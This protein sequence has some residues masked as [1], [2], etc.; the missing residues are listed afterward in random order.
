MQRT[1]V[2]TGSAS[3]IGQAAAAAFAA[4]G[5]KVIGIDRVDADVIA[6]LSTVAGRVSM[7]DAVLDRSGGVVDVVVACAGVGAGP[8]CVPVN[9]FGAVATLVGLRPLLAR[10]GTPRA[11]AITSQALLHPVDDRVVEA[12]L[13][14][15]E[16]LATELA[17]NSPKSYASSKRALS[18]W[19]R[20]AAVTDEWAGHQIVLNGVA[21]GVIRTPLTEGTLATEAGRSMLESWV[22]M[23]LR[24]PATA[25]ELAPLITF[26]CSPANVLVTGNIVFADGGSDPL[27][28]GDD[29]FTTARRTR[30]AA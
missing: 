11:L 22:P 14:N 10:S 12:C 1:V 30:G 23:P 17:A 29:V 5:D 26:L 19:I 16:A 21:P 3:G 7:G 2:I 15:D 20:R 18:R 13:D 9:Y 24:G 27:L 25:A 4:E 28:R 6:D 8:I